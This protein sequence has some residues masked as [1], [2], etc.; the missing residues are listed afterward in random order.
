MKTLE[1]LLQDYSRVELLEYQVVVGGDVWLVL[2][3]Y[4][5]QGATEPKSGIYRLIFKAPLSISFG[6]LNAPTEA[7][8]CVRS[9]MTMDG[10][11][12]E[13]QFADGASINI[14]C[15]EVVWA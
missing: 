13:L 1:S 4:P 2:L 15:R 7:L 10:V 6:K 11:A 5:R 3:G 8:S 14:T 9:T 12:V